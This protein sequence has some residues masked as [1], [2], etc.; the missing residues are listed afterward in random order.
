[1]STLDTIPPRQRLQLVLAALCRRLPSQV[2]GLLDAPRFVEDRA[3]LLRLVDPRWAG[4]AAAAMSPEEAAWL[5][6]LLWERWGGIG[7][8]ALEPTALL[9]LPDS[10]WVGGAP[11]RIPL[12]LMVLGVD[13]GWTVRWSGP[14]INASPPLL[15]IE[16][17]R[18]GAPWHATVQATVLA[19]LQGRPIELVVSGEVQLRRPSV[20]FT[21]SRRS[22]TVLDQAGQPAA[23]VRVQIGERELETDARGRA[24]SRQT[25]PPRAP[26]RVAGFLVGRVPLADDLDEPT[27]EMKRLPR[28]T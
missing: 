4:R 13:D 2:G 24:R 15:L 20:A 14:V 9:D 18:P 1:M 7:Q 17:P 6:G 5:A 10:V 11:V 28:D 21:A 22:L 16:P 12:E 27:I 8:P 3:A 19:R 26:V 23:G 25:F